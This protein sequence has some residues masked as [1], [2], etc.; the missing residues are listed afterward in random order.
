MTEEREEN[1][2]N[3]GPI[4]IPADVYKQIVGKREALLEKLGIV[5]QFPEEVIEEAKGWADGNKEE[6]NTEVIE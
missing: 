1:E 6:V 4:K 5:D 3:D 2:G